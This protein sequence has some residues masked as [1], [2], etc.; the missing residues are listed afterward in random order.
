MFPPSYGR[1]AFRKGRETQESVLPPWPCYFC[2]SRFW[3][4]RTGMLCRLRPEG[5]GGRCEIA[6][7]PKRM[8]GTIDVQLSRRVRANAF[9]GTKVP[10]R[11]AHLGERLDDSG[12]ARPCEGIQPEDALDLFV[13]QPILRLEEDLPPCPLQAPLSVEQR[14]ASTVC[15][16]LLSRVRST[17]SNLSVTICE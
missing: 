11:E 7:C 13:H 5:F 3:N 15:R 6:T 2:S 16:I 1:A 8:G 10:V 9:S 14:P 12:F 4:V 17:V